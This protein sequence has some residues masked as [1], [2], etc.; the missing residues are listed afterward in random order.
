MKDFYQSI[1]RLQEILQIVNELPQSVNPE[2][3]VL[4]SE[5][6]DAVREIV[7]DELGG[8]DIPSQ[9]RLTVSLSSSG[10]SNNQQ[11]VTVN[12]VT[13]SNDVIVAPDPASIATY[14]ECGV[15]CS[16]QASNKLT[17]KCIS[18]PASNLTVNV[19]IIG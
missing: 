18:K 12:G 19:L 15:Y 16:A 1:A 14:G 7:Q 2:D 8:I 9:S 6:T 17:F 5:F 13:T 3:F 4:K 10:W 11:A